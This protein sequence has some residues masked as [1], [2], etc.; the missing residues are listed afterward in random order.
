MQD[1]FR[2]N[3]GASYGRKIN[4]RVGRVS[5]SCEVEELGFAVFHD[6]ACIKENFRHDI[7]TTE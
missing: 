4:R 1:R 3:D 2:G 7:I 6:E 5:S